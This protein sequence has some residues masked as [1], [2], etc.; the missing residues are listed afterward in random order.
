MSENNENNNNL[1]NFLE[2]I[3]IDH[4]IEK[5]NFK[6]LFWCIAIV[7]G[8]TEITK[9]FFPN[10]EPR[11]TVIFWSFFVSV[12]RL[13]LVNNIDREN[14]KEKIIIAFFN[15]IPMALGAIGSYDLV[16]KFIL[17]AFYKT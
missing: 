14:A 6:S 7:V 17:N 16:V 2:N 15:I 3:K 12:M 13:V 8:I 4:F 11:I 1:T 9:I 10:L 5:D